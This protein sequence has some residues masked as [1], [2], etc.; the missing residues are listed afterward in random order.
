MAGG[1]VI[2]VDALPDGV[3]DYALAERAGP[4]PDDAAK[5]QEMVM[6]EKTLIKFR[7]DKSKTARAI[8][9]TPDGTLKTPQLW[10][11]RFAT[12][13]KRWRTAA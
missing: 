5:P 7:G 1:P 11:L 10:K 8:G 3:I 6:I 4:Y 13:R 2:G 9:W 12:M